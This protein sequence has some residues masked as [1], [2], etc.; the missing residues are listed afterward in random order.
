MEETARAGRTVALHLNFCSGTT[1]VPPV[2]HR[3]NRQGGGK[4]RGGHAW[5]GLGAASSFQGS[6]QGASTTTHLNRKEARHA[7]TGPG[8]GAPCLTP[9]DAASHVAQVSRALS[10][11]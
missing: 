4:G 1:R 5:L 3:L 8:T 9:T 7:A 2:P 10:A 11:Q 6:L